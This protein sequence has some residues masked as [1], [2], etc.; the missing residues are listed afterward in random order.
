VKKII[1]LTL[2]FFLL[3]Q[4][5]AEILRV[6]MELSY[7]PFE[8]TNTKGEPDGI[9]V[10]IAQALAQFL[11]R[12]LKIENMSFDGLIPALKTGSIDIIIS[13]L[14]VNDERKKSID[15][16]EPYVNTGLALLVPKNSSI[17]NE[18][19]LDQKNF[20]IAVKKG[21]TAQAWALKNLKQAKVLAFDKENSAV[22]E[23]IQSK[24][25][26]FI[27]D[28]MSI[29][30]HWKKNPEQTKALLQAFQKE[31]WAIGVKKGNPEL[32]KNI[33]LFIEDFRKKKGFS[34]LA[35]KFLKNEK[36]IFKNLGVDFIL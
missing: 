2:S 25:N 32:T 24:A 12:D 18:K 26:A 22:L 27:Y 13:S 28:Q 8:M 15:F 6:G 31:S 36:I 11:K 29:Y 5:S 33:N 17:Q 34:D 7:P 10:G 4:A 30:H 9:S 14:T 16:S 3:L 20:Q 1:L 19:G 21:T 23:V 35:D